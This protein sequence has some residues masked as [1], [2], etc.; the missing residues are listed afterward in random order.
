MTAS[1]RRQNL[2]EDL[3]N[4]DQPISA[5][6][7]AQKYSVSRQI[8]VGDVA[9][10]RASGQNI[11][12]TPRGYIIPGQAIGKI[13][14]IACRHTADQMRDELYAIVDQGCLI[15][16]VIVEHPLYGQLTGNLA[17]ASRFDVDRYLERSRESAAQPLSLLTEGIHLHTIECPSGEAFRKVKERLKDLHILLPS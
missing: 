4:A 9:L 17:L 8:I 10:L 3:K 1:T 5:S 13:C 2:L 16:D 15:R 11:I 14:T 7:F 12:S 6:A